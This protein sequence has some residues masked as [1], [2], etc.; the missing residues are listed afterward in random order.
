M[1]SKYANLSRD[2]KKAVF[3]GVADF[4]GNSAVFSEKVGN[5]TP[6]GMG[7][8]RVE[9]VNHIVRLEQSVD[10]TV[11]GASVPVNASVEI[12]YNVPRG[13]SVTAAA[14][15]TEVLR[16]DGIVQGDYYALEGIVPPSEVNFEL[17]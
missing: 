15:R 4:S 11:A 2:T 13:D 17:I 7:G 10:V 1:T 6:P 3:V 16:L 9:M 8:A 5:Y 14:L 12:R